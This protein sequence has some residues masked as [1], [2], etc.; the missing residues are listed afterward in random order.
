MISD[1]KIKDKKQQYD[2][3]REAAK[4][5]VLQSGNIDKYEILTS[6]QQNNRTS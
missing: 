5:S 2:I 3:N 6:D 4:I 1:V